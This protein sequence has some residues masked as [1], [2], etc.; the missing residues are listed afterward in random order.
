ML[1]SV[2]LRSIG[3]VVFAYQSENESAAELSEGRLAVPTITRQHL[4]TFYARSSQ[5][6]A[7]A[8]HVL[9]IGARELKVL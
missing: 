8:K 6:D 4:E 7:S 9:A 2:L 5:A 3:V 1:A